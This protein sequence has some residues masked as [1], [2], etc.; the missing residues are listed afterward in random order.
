MKGRTAGDIITVV[1]VENASASKE[2]TTET[3]RS[4]SMKAVL[5]ILICS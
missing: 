1:I 4:S 5:E 3:D 2:A